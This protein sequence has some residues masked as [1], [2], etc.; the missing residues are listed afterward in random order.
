MKKPAVTFQ[1]MGLICEAG[2]P[3][4]SLET[5]SRFGILAV[6]VPLVQLVV[7]ILL[8]RHLLSSPR[9]CQ[10]APLFHLD[11]AIAA[12]FHYPEFPFC[13]AIRPRPKSVEPLPRVAL[14]LMN[15]LR[16][17]SLI[18]EEPRTNRR[19]CVIFPTSYT[20]FVPLC[21]T[22]SVLNNVHRSYTQTLTLRALS[23]KLLYTDLPIMCVKVEHKYSCGHSETQKAPCADSKAGGCKGESKRTVQHAGKCPTKCRG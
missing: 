11:R 18:Q 21:V 7:R 16:S 3:V 20:V 15:E 22:K 10:I 1:Q 23:E 6:P 14:F 17:S 2:I 5:N 9:T 4:V 8:V 19:L 13:V 12:L